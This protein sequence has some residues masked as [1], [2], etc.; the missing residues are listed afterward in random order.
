MTT[1]RRLTRLLNELEVLGPLVRKARGDESQ[2]DLAARAGIT[3]V[4]LSR[5]ENGLSRPSK[6]VLRSLILA[7]ETRYVREAK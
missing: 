6:T 2:E 3:P 5:I 7:L 1:I 4:H